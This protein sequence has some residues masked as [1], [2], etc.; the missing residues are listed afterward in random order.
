LPRN[1]AFVAQKP[2]IKIVG[3]ERALPGRVGQGLDFGWAD[4][5]CPYDFKV[6]LIKFEYHREMAGSHTLTHFGLE[7]SSWDWFKFINASGTT[8]MECS[9]LAVFALASATTFLQPHALRIALITAFMAVEVIITVIGFLK[10]LGIQKDDIIGSPRHRLAWQDA[11]WQLLKTACLMVASIWMLSIH[12]LAATPPIAKLFFVSAV[13]FMTLVS[14]VEFIKAR[15]KLHDYRSARL[16]NMDA[17]QNNQRLREL[18][19]TRS[20]SCLAQAVITALTS[21]AVGLNLFY[22]PAHYSALL[23]SAHW[24]T[25]IAAGIAAGIGLVIVIYTKMHEVAEVGRVVKAGKNSMEGKPPPSLPSLDGVPPLTNIRGQIVRERLGLSPA[26]VESGGAP[27]ASAD[28]PLASVGAP[29]ASPDALLASVGAP[30][31]ST[32]A[33]TPTPGASTPRSR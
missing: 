31:A 27:S 16:V 15:K 1:T 5:A 2:I 13:F 17:L 3:A 29:S 20:Y 18:Y 14:A 26:A 30:P 24:I 22:Q 7:D 4:F 23:I 10:T 9:L 33:P 21:L 32:A 6:I 25:G 19:Q 11:L 28:A 12:S 8:L